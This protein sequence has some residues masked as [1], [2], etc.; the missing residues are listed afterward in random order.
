MPSLRSERANTSADDDVLLG[1]FGDL[2]WGDVNAFKSA[3][4]PRQADL[5]ALMDSISFAAGV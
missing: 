4:P 1:V 5:L 2:E 3:M